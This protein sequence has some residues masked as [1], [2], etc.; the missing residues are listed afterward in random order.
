MPAMLMS[1]LW[2]WWGLSGCSSSTF[3]SVG[4]AETSLPVV[5]S[6]S[7]PDWISPEYLMGKFNPAEHPDFVEIDIQYADRSGQYL[8]KEVMKAFIQMYRDAKKEGITLQ[9]R[10]ATRNFDNQKRI[11]ENKWHGRTLLENGMDAS[12]QISDP[13]QRALKI[14][15]YSSMPG[16]SRHHWGTDIDLNAFENSWFEKGE[17]LKLYRWLK[18]NAHKYGFC[19]PYTALGA[20]RVTGYQE[21][22]WHWTY[23]PLSVPLTRYAREHLKDS[24]IAGF[25]GAETATKIGVVDKY[26][27]GIHPSCMQ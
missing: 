19:Q 11:W 21:E 8:R 23:M 26:V 18:T 17:G 6:D 20:E 16:S 3:S 9:I 13:V 15:E 7:F 14:L 22:R 1:V 25:D 5:L 24:M 2:V 4:K 12:G 27:L 10:S